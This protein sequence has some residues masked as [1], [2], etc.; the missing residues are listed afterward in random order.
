MDEPM[1]MVG[2]DWIVVVLK[3]L[4]SPLKSKAVYLDHT[5]EECAVV[6]TLSIDSTVNFGAS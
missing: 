4:D 5:K 6:Y 2:L 3:S 1:S